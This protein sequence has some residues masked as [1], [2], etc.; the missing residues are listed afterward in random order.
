MSVERFFVGLIAAFIGNYLGDIATM[1]DC[2]TKS[3]AKLLGG[4]TITCEVLK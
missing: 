3:K 4:T 1:R 2:A